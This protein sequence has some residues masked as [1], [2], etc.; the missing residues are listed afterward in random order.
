MLI[1]QV[2]LDFANWLDGNHWWLVKI[3]FVASS[4]GLFVLSMFGLDLLIHSSKW[5]K[6]VVPRWMHQSIYIVDRH[7]GEHEEP[8]A[9]P[10]FVRKLISWLVHYWQVAGVALL[11]GALC[12]ELSYHLPELGKNFPDRSNWWIINTGACLL[13][14]ALILAWQERR[15][16]SEEYRNYC[17]MRALYKSAD[18]RLGLILRDLESSMHRQ[19]DD[20]T[21]QR[22][23]AEAQDILYQLGREALSENADWLIL[24]RARPLEPFM[25]G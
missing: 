20:W 4:F 2:N 10:H 17:S 23:V 22:L 18:R 11:I 19:S 15:F 7:F 8:I 9:E 6:P 1:S 14:G 25:A 16:Y 24:H 3:A 5:I 13:S 21:R 12:F